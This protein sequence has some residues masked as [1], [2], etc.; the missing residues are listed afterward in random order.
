MEGGHRAIIFSRLGGVK[1]ETYSEGLHLRIPW[2]QY[3]I[4]YDIRFVQTPFYVNSST[5]FQMNL[6]GSAS[7]SCYAGIQLHALTKISGCLG[8]SS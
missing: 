7:K 4:V 8:V 5:F 1:D 6:S 2:L 3:P